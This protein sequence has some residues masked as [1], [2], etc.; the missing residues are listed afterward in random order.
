MLR[1]I[2]TLPLHILLRIQKNKVR[3]YCVF[4]S[5]CNMFI[6]DSSDNNAYCDML[7]THVM[8]CWN[9]FVNKHLFCDNNK[10]SLHSKVGFK[11]YDYLHTDYLSWRITYVMTF[12]CHDPCRHIPTIRCS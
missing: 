4:L 8:F 6:D 1:Y 12:H 3:T 5:T 9:D 10:I 7:R 2:Y 11:C